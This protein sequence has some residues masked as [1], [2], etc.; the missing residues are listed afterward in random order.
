LSGGGILGS[1]GSTSGGGSSGGMLGGTSGFLSGASGF[2]SGTGGGTA[3]AGFGGGFGGTGRG[4][5]YSY[6]NNTFMGPNY[7]NP[8]SLGMPNAN[9]RAT[10]GTVLYNVANTTG[11][12]GTGTATVNRNTNSQNANA[13]GIRRAPSYSTALGFPYRPPA[14]PRLQADVQQVIANSSRLPSR[15]SIQVSMDGRIVVLKGTVE[16]D[17]ERS[18]AEALVRLTPGIEGVRNELGVLRAAEGP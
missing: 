14:S 2:L 7:G 4:G 16:D 12:T 9:G 1:L 17:H 6:G 3:G 15:A 8:L 18:L 13:T 5:A 10:F 11:T